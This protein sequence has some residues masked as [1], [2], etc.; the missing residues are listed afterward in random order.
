MCK[1]DVNDKEEEEEKDDDEEEE[2]DDEEG[3]DEDEEEQD[4]GEQS[5]DSSSS[6]DSK[7]RRSKR[8]RQKRNRSYKNSEKQ[9]SNKKLKSSKPSKSH[10]TGD[11]ELDNLLTVFVLNS[12]NELAKNGKSDI[13]S[14]KKVLEKTKEEKYIEKNMFGPFLPLNKDKKVVVI[15]FD[16]VFETLNELILLAKKYDP[17][18]EYDCNIDMKKLHRILEPLEELNEMIGLTKFKKS[19]LDQLVHFLTGNYDMNM[20]HTCLF[21]GPGMGKTTCAQILGN[22]YAKCGILSKG[23]LILAKREDF[24]GEFLGS[25]TI[26]TKK[27]LDRCKGNVLFIDEVYSLGSGNGNNRDSFSKE[28]VD[29]INSFLSENKD[30]ICIIAG[31]KEE[32]EKCFFQLNNGLDRRFPYKHFLDNY[33]PKEMMQMFNKFVL[34][35][36]WRFDLDLDLNTLEKFFI[37]HEKCFP[38]FGGDIKTLLDKC[39]VLHS[40]KTIMLDKSLWK[41]LSFQDISQGFILY[42]EERQVKKDSP[43]HLHMYL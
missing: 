19:I 32:V 22:I 4:D 9:K 38:Y 10:S 27:L 26:K 43:S 42:L 29:A 17:G 21:S 5:S 30:F 31:Y 16:K 3:D 13:T 12:I 41:C 2:G 40:R 14:A 39:K 11:M 15:T 25:T 36:E 1:D 18:V 35:D 7:P 24:I 28:A 37:E 20:L 23:E 33:T 34:D 6:D 8:L